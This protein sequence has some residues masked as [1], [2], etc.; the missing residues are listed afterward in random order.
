METIVLH[1]PVGPVHVTADAAVIHRIS[2]GTGPAE[3]R[4]TSLLRRAADQLT[5]Y[6]AGA[7]RTFDLPLV[8]P[9]TPFQ[10]RVR[11][12]MIAIPYGETISYGALAKQIGGVA[13]AVGQACAHNPVPIIVPCHRVLAAGGAIGGFSGGD[14][15]PTKRALLAHE[16]GAIF[17]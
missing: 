9:E 17:A 3:T 14:G 1:S 2:I 12:A 4:E 11:A 5:G 13:R 16:A 8:P 7:A 10:V 6:F 15:T